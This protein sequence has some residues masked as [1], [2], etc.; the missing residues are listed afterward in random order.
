MYDYEGVK[1]YWAQKAQKS[2]NPC[3][4]NNKWQD[5]YAFEVRISAFKKSDFKGFKKIVDIGCGI[6]DYTSYFAKLADPDAKIIG[7]DFPFNIEIA[8]RKHGDESKIDFLEGSVPSPAIKETVKNADAVVMT[9]VYVHMPQESRAALLNYFQK[10]KK[11]ARIFLLEY[12]PEEVPEFQKGLGYK[13]VETPKQT[14]GLFGRH[15]LKIEEIR[16]V[17]FV[18]SLVFH[19]LGGNFFSYFLT[20]I[21]ECFIKLVRSKRSKYK[22][23]IFSNA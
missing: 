22:L 1:N 4:Y 8:K 18:D 7:F 13:E 9:T 23:F 10:M 17:N 11:G 15:N 21:G 5:K 20:K 16:H 12:F 14:I 19:H 3:H 2:E 6:G